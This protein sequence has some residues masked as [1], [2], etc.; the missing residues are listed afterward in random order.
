M[1]TSG[2]HLKTGTLR[3]ICTSMRK[4]PEGAAHGRFQPLHNG[5]VEYLL[6]AK[7]RCDFLWIGITQFN[8]N[9]LFDSPHDPHRQNLENNP[10]TYFERVEMVTSVI[11]DEGVEVGQFGIVPFPID[12]PEH[13]NGFLSIQ[14]PV[15]TTIYDDWNRHKIGVLN[16]CGYKV[17][18]LWER[19]YKQFDGI[20]IRDL[21]YAGDDQW[22]EMV[23]PATAKVVQ[24]YGIA[25]RIRKLR[26]TSGHG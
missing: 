4:Y 10:M 6:A 2:N 12:T 1:M 20:T 9:S 21:M 16:D 23:P 5:H 18:V 17:E 24:R 11:V 15:F 25:D 3:S 13:L 26:D 14:V 19:G 7:D 22:K 8:I